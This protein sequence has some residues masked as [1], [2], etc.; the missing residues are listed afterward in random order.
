MRIYY[1][2]VGGDWDYV[3]A[4][5]T[6]GMSALQKRQAIEATLDGVLTTTVGSNSELKITGNAGQQLDKLDFTVD[7]GGFT[8]PKVVSKTSPVTV[9]P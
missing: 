4:D 2:L 6:N 7:F 8:G 1:E 3:S 9:T 5:M